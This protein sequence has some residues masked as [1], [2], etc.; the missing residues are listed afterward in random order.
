MTPSVAV[1]RAPRTFTFFAGLAALLAVLELGRLVIFAVYPVRPTAWS[2]APWSPFMTRHACTTVY[3]SAATTIEQTPDVYSLAASS[4]AAIPRPDGR[5]PARSGRSR[6]I[7]Y[8]Y[9]PTFLLVPRALAVVAPEFVAF[10]HVWLL[11][12]AALVIAGMAAI[13]R[14]MDTATGSRSL[15]LLPLA[16]VPLTTMYALQIG[17]AQ[18]LFV[19]LAAVALL[20]SSAAAMPWAGCCSPTRSSASCSP[21]CCSS[22]WRSGGNGGPSAGRPGGP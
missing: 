15:W 2:V 16:I 22:I 5:C 12:N 21:P 3:W 20:A 8:E 13:A 10:R 14:R 19:V 7:P 17:N 1:A 6:S 18:L 9:P 4:A 11:L